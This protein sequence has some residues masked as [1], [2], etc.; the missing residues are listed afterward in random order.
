MDCQSPKAMARSPKRRLGAPPDGRCRGRSGHEAGLLSRRSCRRP[1]QK[2][3][4]RNLL[5][6][7]REC[8]STPEA[9]Q[10]GSA[11]LNCNKLTSS[12]SHIGIRAPPDPCKS[13]SGRQRPHL[14]H[15][16]W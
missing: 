11:G 9:G 13:Q 8:V 14:L 12:S 6:Q 5:N 10:G 7:R 15:T 4:E 1:W 3:G 2:A 16:S